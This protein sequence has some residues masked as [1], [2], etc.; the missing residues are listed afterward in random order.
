MSRSIWYLVNATVASAVTCTD[1]LNS[2]GPYFDWTICDA[3]DNNL[4]SF[5]QNN[6]VESPEKCFYSNLIE[7]ATD[8]SEIDI[9]S[10]SR[11]CKS[12]AAQ[13]KRDLV[14]EM[15]AITAQCYNDPF[16]S[17]KDQRCERFHRALLKIEVDE[18]SMKN[19]PLKERMEKAKTFPELADIFNTVS[20]ADTQS[21]RYSFR[22]TV[23]GKIKNLYGYSTMQMAGTVA[24]GLALVAAGRAVARSN[25]VRNGM[26]WLSGKKKIVES[27]AVTK[28]VEPEATNEDVP[29]VN[30]N[31]KTC[32]EVLFTG[33]PDTD[34]HVC[35]ALGDRLRSQYIL[36]PHGEPSCPASTLKAIKR[37][38]TFSEID[39]LT[40]LPACKSAANQYL[41]TLVD[42]LLTKTF[43][44][45]DNLLQGFPS[46]TCRGF[47]N[48]ILASRFDANR[49]GKCTLNSR[50][51]AVNS[52]EELSALVSLSEFDGNCMHAVAHFSQEKAR[53][54]A[55]FWSLL[56]IAGGIILVVLV[57][58]SITAFFMLRRHS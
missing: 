17:K 51:A 35:I 22:H 21:C 10:S 49:A 1:V 34:A 16:E 11:H 48:G 4:N 32:E 40:T 50:L 41:L 57:G 14:S 6:P 8:I 31:V 36:V 37:A 18:R 30:P 39:Q 19:C 53:K 52:F 13:R 33:E 29:P 9:Y 58:G 54:L 20:A 12:V 47:N 55:S 27:P 56:V 5:L 15:K 42:A 38:S 2:G 45:R 7:R 23:K 25:F 43:Q 3:F 26:N 28:T 24:A 44:C 46:W